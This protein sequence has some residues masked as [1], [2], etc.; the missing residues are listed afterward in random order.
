VASV[1]QLGASRC[2]RMRMA[3]HVTNPRPC[4]R[5]LAEQES[6]RVEMNL[7]CGADGA[8]EERGEHSGFESLASDVSDDDQRA[9]IARVGKH[10]E[11]ISTPLRARAVDAVDGESGVGEV[12]SG[13]RYCWISARETIS[14]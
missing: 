4:N 8:D 12:F 9:S 7:E 11:E 13:M 3:R 10:L 14:R 6:C 2:H 5:S 1:G